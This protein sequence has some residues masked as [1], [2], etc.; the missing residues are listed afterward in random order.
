MR[1]LNTTGALAIAAL[2]AFA[3]PAQ[4][5]EGDRQDLFGLANRHADLTAGIDSENADQLNLAW[6]VETEEEV[7]HAP[8][9]R[10]DL[11]F[12]ASVEG[13]AYAID[14]RTGEV[15]W[16]TSFTDQP[17]ALSQWPC[18]G[19]FPFHHHGLTHKNSD[20]PETVEKPSRRPPRAGFRILPL[21]P[22]AKRFRPAH[23]VS[24][25]TTAFKE[26]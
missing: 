21:A 19:S 5:Q 11:L 1:I 26:E 20:S 7:T 22:G 14:T 15:V 6:M 2:S 18:N 3:S 16:S 25:R 23:D 8:L 13:D 17:K 4:A 24:S 12:E 9:V 10:G